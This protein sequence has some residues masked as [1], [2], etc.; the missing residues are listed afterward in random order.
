MFQQSL[1]GILRSYYDI[2]GNESQR[3]N[4]K[5]RKSLQ[6]SNRLEIIEKLSHS[7]KQM[8]DWEKYRTNY[9]ICSKHSL[10]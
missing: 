2:Q 8:S 10:Q 9:F 5:L 3:K 7:K 4:K 1:Q 6:L